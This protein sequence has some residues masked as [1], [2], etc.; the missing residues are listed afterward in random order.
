M[1]HYF[2]LSIILFVLFS[3]KESGIYND[4][5]I[6]YAPV[7]LTPEEKEM[8]ARA[9]EPLHKR[10]EQEFKMLASDIKA[11]HYHTDALSGHFHEVRG[12]FAYAVALLDL[13]DPQYRQRAFDVIEKTISLQD[14]DPR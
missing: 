1:K 11:W 5:Y 4:G 7:R 8:V 2:F 9:I 10:Y 14:V 13:G 12:S 6:T 3:C